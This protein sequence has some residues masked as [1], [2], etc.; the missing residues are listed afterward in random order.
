MAGSPGKRLGYCV[1]GYAWAPGAPGLYDVDGCQPSG[2]VKR[3]GKICPCGGLVP[4]AVPWLGLPYCARCSL[5]GTPALELPFYSRIVLKIVKMEIFTVIS[6]IT[7]T[8]ST[9][10]GA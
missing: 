6:I 4:G 8:I 2:P 10:T 1:P 7:Y 9:A 5:P 3:S